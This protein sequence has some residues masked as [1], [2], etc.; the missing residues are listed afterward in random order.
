[1]HMHC[2]TL[3]FA[4]L[5]TYGVVFSGPVIFLEA[6]YVA[7]LSSAEATPD[8]AGGN[9]WMD[10]YVAPAT[11]RPRKIGFGVQVS[12]WPSKAVTAA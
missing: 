2:C 4:V 3:L 9:I 11:G 8:D 6:C 1:M 5:D 10:W 7:V 12:T